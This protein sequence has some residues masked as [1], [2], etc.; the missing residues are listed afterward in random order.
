MPQHARG[1]HYFSRIA[2]FLKCTNNHEA[3]ADKIYSKIKSE[4]EFGFG[5]TK[6]EKCGSNINVSV[7]PGGEWEYTIFP[8]PQGK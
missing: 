5:S 2:E 7:R 8:P 6:C 3:I 1:A 4:S